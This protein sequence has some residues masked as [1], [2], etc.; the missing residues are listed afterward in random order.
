MV[1]LT[2]GADNAHGKAVMINYLLTTNGAMYQGKLIIRVLGISIRGTGA[3]VVLL[4]IFMM[5]GAASV[6]R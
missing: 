5:N 6:L 2:N 4:G 3:V 1:M